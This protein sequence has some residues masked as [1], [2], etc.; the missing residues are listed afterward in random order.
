MSLPP[1]CE[2]G[3]CCC[4]VGS[5]AP[6]REVWQPAVL[7]TW[8]MWLCCSMTTVLYHATWK[9]WAILDTA[10]KLANGPT[11]L[12]TP[13]RAPAVRT[14][15]TWEGGVAWPTYV[16][17][18]PVRAVAVRGLLSTIS[19]THARGRCSHK[20]R[21]VGREWLPATWERDVAILY[22]KPLASARSLIWGIGNWNGL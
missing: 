6:M 13:T 3:Q 18:I 14:S 19:D 2:V 1:S 4:H 20:A 8:E 5:V 11:Y 22:S 9:A 16:Y 15:A 17:M 21:A 7:S 10:R 12:Q